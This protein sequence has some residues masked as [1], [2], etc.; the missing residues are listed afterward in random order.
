[1]QAF[2]RTRCGGSVRA[3]RCGRAWR[4]IVQIL[5]GAGL[6]L[7]GES[8]RSSPPPQ[9]HTPPDPPVISSPLAGAFIADGSPAFLGHAEP[10]ATVTITE[11]TRVLANGR[12]NPRGE[13]SLSPRPGLVDGAHE[14]A[15][16]AT[17]AAGNRSA[18]SNLLRFTIDRV[19]PAPPSIDHP[20]ANQIIPP[21][22]LA[23]SG[24]AEPGAAI[25]VTLDSLDLGV[26]G[27]AG[28]SG[29][30]SEAVSTNL[31]GTG[32]TLS[33][34]AIDRA[35]NRSARSAQVPFSID[36][37]GSISPV[38]GEHGRIDL[39]ALSQSS[40]NYDPALGSLRLRNVV[41][42]QKE[43]LHGASENYEFYLVAMVT[44]RD[45]QSGEIVRVIER[46][47]RVLNR[48]NPDHGTDDHGAGDNLTDDHGDDH[49]EGARPTEIVLDITWPG[50]AAG[51]DAQPI[52][53]GRTVVYDLAIDFARRWVGAGHGSPCPR[54][55]RIVP[56]PP[57]VGN[58]P[59]DDPSEGTQEL[60]PVVA[61]LEDSV[62]AAAIGTIHIQRA[63]TDGDTLPDVEDFLLGDAG[64][65]H[66][67]RDDLRVVVGGSTDLGQ[68][69]TGPLPVTIFAGDLPLVRFL[70]VFERGN[71][72]D[73]RGL[74]LNTEGSPAEGLVVEGS[75]LRLPRGGRLAV[76]SPSPK[77]ALGSGARLIVGEGT[78]DA[79]D[80]GRGCFANGAVPL[81]QGCNQPCTDDGIF[82]RASAAEQAA[83]S[84]SRFGC[85]SDRE[86]GGEPIM[87]VTCDVSWTEPPV[88]CPLSAVCLSP[89]AHWRLEI[90]PLVCGATVCDQGDAASD[91]CMDLACVPD[92]G[93]ESTHCG[94]VPR[95]DGSPCTLPGHPRPSPCR[96][97]CDHGRCVPGARVTDGTAC[98]GVQDPI[99]GDCL[100]PLCRQG[101]C[102]NQQAVPDERSCVDSDANPCTI[103]RC[104]PGQGVCNQH[105]LVRPTGTPC[106]PDAQ[107]DCVQPLCG[108]GG[109]C[110]LVPDSSQMGSFSLADD[111]T[112]VIVSSTD[113]LLEQ[114]SA[115]T[116]CCWFCEEQTLTALAM[117]RL[118]Y[119]G[120]VTRYGIN[121]ELADP[122]DIMLN[123]VPAGTVDGVAD[124]RFR[125]MVRPFPNTECLP[126]GKAVTRSVPPFG[127]IPSDA[128]CD[129]PAGTCVNSH[130]DLDDN[131]A[132]LH[133]E[134]T[135]D[136]HFY[137]KDD[138][139]LPIN[140]DDDGWG[141]DSVLEEANGLGPTVCVY[142]VYSFDHGTSHGSGHKNTCCSWDVSHDRPE[143]HPF[144]A[145][146]WHGSPDDGP[147]TW[148]FGVFQDDSNRYN[149]EHCGDN[150]GNTWSAAPR[151]L[152]LRFPFS[153]QSSDF[154]ICAR[155]R[156]AHSVA[157]GAS[158]SVPPWNVTTAMQPEQF[159]EQKQLRV[160]PSGALALEIEEEFDSETRVGF[161]AC[162]NTAGAKGYLLVEVAVGCTY[163]DDNCV[164]VD[165]QN[166]DGYYFGEVEFQTGTACGIVI[167]Q[168]P[169][170]IPSPRAPI[171]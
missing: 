48:R 79:V 8:A 103:P 94:L 140:G 17:D 125:A 27:V 115:F 152:T 134:I 11:G 75:G 150:N 45:A 105:G 163:G 22:G 21:F 151:D 77:G 25:A 171:P 90:N 37:D 110:E 133:A 52:P 82:S 109:Q 158:T 7:A 88:A 153:F 144:D 116:D 165:G 64:S 167:P 73:L 93:N 139:Y 84:A 20:V 113:P 41:R 161:E 99:A 32:H 98:P 31:S 54:G 10:F 69:F 29:D 62:R 23:V 70:W 111:P 147:R 107:D 138:R 145:V 53:Y 33:A 2:N 136:N 58:D 14:V 44:L 137:S 76:S 149:F 30:F 40:G 120:K 80:L 159:T 157:G 24:S 164:D 39:I 117:E 87:V 60:L 81:S 143:I 67:N 170:P 155:V 83:S 168:S 72:L 162:A 55:T 66:S 95:P 91:P 78:G 126:D 74:T 130:V 51:E 106:A 28:S 124:D 50:S 49:G 118:T 100:A 12:V 89:E 38:S 68:R 146:W 129:T 97:A 19:P 35:G 3:R 154:P 119:C 59:E 46:S 43:G 63:D 92:P 96:S 61:C 127:P 142:G 4:P 123:M 131:L 141:I 132:C 26:A 85:C 9:D 16:T 34:I 114:S 122:N 112:N 1:M 169:S 135:P 128:A 65:I 104:V 160:Q 121:D 71:T 101:S 13:F 36:V 108:E 18:P 6:M 5:I 102:V 15:A 57:K 56:G 166:T 47:T 148:R 156:R 86:P 42:I